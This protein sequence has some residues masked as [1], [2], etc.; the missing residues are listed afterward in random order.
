M[1]YRQ[2][3]IVR[4]TWK[5]IETFVGIDCRVTEDSFF[6]GCAILNG[7][8]VDTILVSTQDGEQHF[9]LIVP[10]ELVSHR[11]AIKMIKVNCKFKLF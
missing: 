11:V 4:A 1:R 7:C 10:E 2:C 9:R 5:E 6:M 3:P 8:F